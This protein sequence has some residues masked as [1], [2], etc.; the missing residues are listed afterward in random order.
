MAFTFPSLVPGRDP[1]LVAEEHDENENITCLSSNMQTPNTKD[2]YARWIEATSPLV[3]CGNATPFSPSLI[4]RGTPTPAKGSA[5]AGASPQALDCPACEEDDPH[6]QKW[7]EATGRLSFTPMKDLLDLECG[8]NAPPPAQQQ[9]TAGTAAGGLEPVSAG[10][11]C[12][13]GVNEVAQEDGA[14]GR[15]SCA[16][17]VLASTQATKANTSSLCD[18]FNALAVAPLEQSACKR[19][20]DAAPKGAMHSASHQLL[21]EALEGSFTPATVQPFSASASARH[22]IRTARTPVERV[23]ELMAGEESDKGEEEVDSGAR[24]L[25]ARFEDHDEDGA[26][27]AAAAGDEDPEGFDGAGSTPGS[28]DGSS[29]EMAPD[30]LQL[31]TPGAAAHMSACFAREAWE[32]GMTPMNELLALMATPAPTQ[33]GLDEL[34]G[35]P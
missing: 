18:M 20:T 26:R 9:H 4:L 3:D 14:Q 17:N 13:A 11:M 31:L 1:K 5:C 23:L 33:G 29:D 12:H 19:A 8:P 16:N 35:V 30:E 28:P 22:T 10:G 25:T 34:L 2:R 24:N 27:A 15:D 32:A 7:L 6:F 21:Y